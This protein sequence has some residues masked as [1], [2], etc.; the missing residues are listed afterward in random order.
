MTPPRRADGKVVD[1]VEL[2]L[3]PAPDAALLYGV[4]DPDDVAAA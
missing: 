4:T 1:G 2:V 3:L